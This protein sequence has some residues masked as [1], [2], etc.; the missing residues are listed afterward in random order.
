[1]TATDRSVTAGPTRGAELVDPLARGWAPQ[2]KGV[3]HTI[4]GVLARHFGGMLLGQDI[5][6]DVVDFT[7]DLS[8]IPL[9]GMDDV[10]CVLVG[11][12]RQTSVEPVAAAVRARAMPGKMVWVLIGSEELY[13]PVK[14]AT[15]KRRCVL[16]S[17][18]VMATLLDS[19]EPIQTLKEEIG[20]WAPRRSLIP[21]DI[22]HSAAGGM[23][24]GRQVEFKRLR[25]EETTCF[26]LAGPGRAGKTSIAKQYLRSLRDELS[27]RV[28]A[29]FFIDLMECE[30]GNLNLDGYMRLIG[31]RI[32][33]K[34]EAHSPTEFITLLRNLV[35]DLGQPV[36]VVLDEADDLCLDNDSSTLIALAIREGLMRV[37]MCGRGDLFRTM[38]AADSHFSERLELLRI[39]PLDEHAGRRLLVEP[40]AALGIHLDDRQC[41]TQILQLTGCFPHLIQ[42]YAKRLAEYAIE[43]G[44]NRLTWDDLDALKFDWEIATQFMS[45]LQE[46]RDPVAKLV[47][48]CMLRDERNVWSMAEVTRLIPGLGVDRAIDLCNELVIS[49]ILIWHAGSGSYRLAN[50]AMKVYAKELGYLDVAYE[51]ARRAFER[52]KE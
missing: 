39:G 4:P 16:M 18:E 6:R 51:E 34:R 26:A 36:N 37:V 28:I 40:L 32:G 13:E 8:H 12:T 11:G 27:S 2:T 38:N 47:A 25:E 1:M 35:A 5:G 41:V 49:N 29:S 15:E 17:R 30:R 46:L 14:F 23:F 44:K 43:V 52:R 7:L 33:L 21:Y 22:L 31:R 45:P 9:K 10:R 42:L 3:A 48:L 50:A 24:F 20:R 19:R